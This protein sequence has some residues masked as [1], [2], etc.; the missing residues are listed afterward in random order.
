MRLEGFRSVLRL[1]LNYPYWKD[2]V[3]VE[4]WSWNLMV[5]TCLKFLLKKKKNQSTNSLPPSPKVKSSLKLFCCLRFFCSTSG[6]SYLYYGASLYCAVLSHF[7]NTL[8]RFEVIAKGSL[9]YV[10]LVRTTL[11]TSRGITPWFLSINVI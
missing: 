3:L 5:V 4:I 8:F 1:P 10:N 7:W 6:S 11:E 9:N 2:C